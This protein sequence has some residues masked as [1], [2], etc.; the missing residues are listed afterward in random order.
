[1]KNRART[2]RKATTKQERA[3]A[4]RLGGRR[5][6]GSGML[7]EKGDGR[8]LGRFRIE[9]KLST[10]DRFRMTSD[11]WATLRHVALNAGE[12]PVVQV[13]LTVPT[14]GYLDLAVVDLDDYQQMM[15]NDLTELGGWEATTQPTTPL[16]V[17][18]SVEHW[19]SRGEFSAIM[20]YL[21][22]RSG[23]KP[24]SLVVMGFDDFVRRADRLV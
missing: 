8:V 21:R 9:N 3:S 18:L 1:M 15:D 10:H 12:R 14:G 16:G 19:L 23:K 20:L 22:N 2:I 13:R 24:F 6:P 7:D 4:S 17:M 5:T 11:I